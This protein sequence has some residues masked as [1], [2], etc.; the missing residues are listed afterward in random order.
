MANFLKAVRFNIVSSFA[1]VFTTLEYNL[2]RALDSISK[3]K[4][5]EERS[6]KK[7]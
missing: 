3:G 7:R 4:W 2:F 6:L 5:L 1:L